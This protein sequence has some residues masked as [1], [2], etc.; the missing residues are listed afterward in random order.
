MG[1]KCGSLNA[2]NDSLPTFNAIFLF[3]VGISE[4]TNINVF[5]EFTKKKLFQIEL[6]N[7]LLFIV[8]TP[9]PKHILER[10]LQV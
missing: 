8:L 6:H 9:H 2:K 5:N 10:L 7:N 3:F 1:L 4:I